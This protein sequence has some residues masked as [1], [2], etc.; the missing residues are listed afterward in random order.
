MVND[1][2]AEK[3]ALADA[4]K[5]ASAEI[6]DENSAKTDFSANILS[7]TEISAFVES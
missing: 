6:S 7:P 3:L 5:V 1:H 2:F 4:E